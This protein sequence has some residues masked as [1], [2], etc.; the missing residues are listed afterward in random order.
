VVTQTI[1]SP[2]TEIVHLLTPAVGG[3]RLDLT[4]RW[5]PPPVSKAEAAQA[6]D[7]IAAHL[8]ATAEAYKDTIEKAGP[9][10]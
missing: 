10:G 1:G 7:T 9:P 4:A 8:Q 6:A 2:D 3:T 5:P